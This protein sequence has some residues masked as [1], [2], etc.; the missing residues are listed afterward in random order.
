VE[1]HYPGRTVAKRYDRPETVQALQ[2]RIAANGHIG[3]ERHLR[4]NIAQFTGSGCPYPNNRKG[5]PVNLV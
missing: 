2:P 4:I 1:P 3:A 5:R